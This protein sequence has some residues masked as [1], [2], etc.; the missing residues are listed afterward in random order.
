[1]RELQGAKRFAIKAEALS[2][3]NSVAHRMRYKRSTTRQ[4]L[5]PW[6]GNIVALDSSMLFR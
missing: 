5:E 6:D 4:L 2:D 1:M 3:T